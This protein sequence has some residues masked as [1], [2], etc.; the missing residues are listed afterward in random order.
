M[1]TAFQFLVAFIIAITVPALSSGS[2]QSGPGSTGVR[3]T[4]TATS[5][6][7]TLHLASG[8]WSV[9]SGQLPGADV[10][11]SNSE[12]T[13]Y[14]FA[15]YPG[16][17]TINDSGKLPSL[18]SPNTAVYQSGCS[19]QYTVTGFE[20][21]YC[22]DQPSLEIEVDFYHRHQ[23]GL[24]DGFFPFVTIPLQGLPG[25]TDGTVQR[26]VVIVDLRGGVGVNGPFTIMADGDGM[27]DPLGQEQDKFAYGFRVPNLVGLNTG[28]VI[29]GLGNSVIGFRWSN[30]G[31]DYG[32]ESVGMANNTYLELMPGHD[33]RDLHFFAGT[34]L[35][36]FGDACG[37]LVGEPYCS[38]D[39]SGTPCPCA[40]PSPG[41]NVEGC[42]NSVNGINGGRLE[43]TGNANLSNDSILLR[44]LR[45][46]AT[47]P[48]LFFQGTQRVNNGVGDLFGDGLRCAGGSVVRIGTHA[49]VNGQVEFP[50]QSD[51]PVS[52]RGGVMIPSLRTYQ[53]WYR[54][55]ASF[56]TSAAF[57][58]TNGWELIWG[59]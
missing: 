58:L 47:S 48:L 38:G 24:N 25:S 6:S 43:V 23:L 5:H 32:A 12:A 13:S 54:N 27:F 26:W 20:L 30:N 35:R 56:C 37:A 22:T 31:V 10:L 34:H 28:P 51:P 44:A 7:A 15:L 40:N 45:L 16:V 57:N 14:F 49:A 52:V 46:P 42:R 11:Y 19:T 33:L 50:L 36:L 53:G 29:A 55:A 18:T 1:S 9:S 8:N 2:P 17:E 41:L 39:D 3:V 21:G 4:S 59:P